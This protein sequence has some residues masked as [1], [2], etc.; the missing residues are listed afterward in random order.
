MSD[1]KYLFAYTVPLAALVSLMSNGVLTFAAP[2]YTFIFIPI[3][4]M[5]LADFDKKYSPAQKENRLNNFFFDILL[6]WHNQLYRGIQFN[7]NFG[8]RKN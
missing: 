1:L 2:I 8:K 6:F 5:I 4:E 3:L 7:S